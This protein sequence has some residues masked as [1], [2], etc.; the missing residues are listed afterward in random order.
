MKNFRIASALILGLAGPLTAD[1]EIPE[2]FR[3]T[4]PEIAE[5]E[6]NL[7]R[8]LAAIGPSMADEMQT[9]REVRRQ[10]AEGK[11]IQ[12]E[13]LLEKFRTRYQR[14]NEFLKPP[15]AFKPVT[16]ASDTTPVIYLFQGTGVLAVQEML[17]GNRTQADQLLDDMLRWSRLLRNARPNLVQGAISR[18]GWET[19]FSLLLQD[20]TRHPD[21]TKRLDEIV[22]FQAENKME[23]A[24]FIESVKSE[25]RWLVQ[26]GGYRE[27]L[28]NDVYADSVTTFLR[29][30]FDEL[31][32]EQLQKLPYDH[33]AE[34]RRDN[35]ERARLLEFLKNATPMI[36]WP[37]FKLP[38]TR[39]TLAD[40]MK[41]PNGLGDLL[42]EQTEPILTNGMWSSALSRGALLDACLLW[43]KLEQE[44]K[45]IEASRFTAFLDPV[46][47]KPL[48]IDLKRRIIRSRGPNQKVDSPDDNADPLPAAGFF[49]GG[50]DPLVVVP[51][52]RTRVAGSH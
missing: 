22:K 33:Q 10:L 49:R 36:E 37:S 24:E 52:W 50:D 6:N 41:R 2:A 44:G 5:S 48:G 7:P 25:Y 38:D 31:S 46:D 14:A 15:L 39:A 32:K 23:R 27:I 42:H 51:R 1:V 28:K 20:W 19:A 21:Q 13:A 9:V 12:D 18:H 43:L 40:Y 8:F 17:E 34:M 11:P 35:A 47:G 29:S 26:L 4:G 45:T 3:F 16:E 30:P